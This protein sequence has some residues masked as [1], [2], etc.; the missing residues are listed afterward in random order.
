ML[1]ILD[2]RPDALFVLCE[3]SEHTHANDPKLADEAEM[4]NERRFLTL[5]LTCGRRIDAGMYAYVR[6]NGMSEEEYAFF[7][8]QGLREHFI[9]GH[10]YYM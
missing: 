5:D 2:V 4:Y 3:S 6:D 1:A 7:M 8:K 9:I 10:D